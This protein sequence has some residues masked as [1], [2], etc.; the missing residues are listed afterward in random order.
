LTTAATPAGSYPLTI[1]GTSGAV[2]HSAI[3][4]LV[5]SVAGD[6]SISVTPAS[7]T[8]GRGGSTTYSV[9]ITATPGFSGTVNLSAGG[10]PKFVTATFSPASV[11]QSGTSVLTVTTR[12][13]VKTGSS[14]LSITG[15]SGSLVHSTN[16]TLII[17]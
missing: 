12:K 11:V 10:A 1:T 4:T 5:V 13:Q 14:T 3:V 8:I 16:I 6:F 7:R 2:V 9:S 17:Q 15:T